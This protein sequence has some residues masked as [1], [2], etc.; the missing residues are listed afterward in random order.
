MYYSQ[1]GT[2]QAIEFETKIEKDGHIY[3]PETFQHAYGKSARLIV[4]LPEEN[5]VRTKKW[6][7]GSAKGIF[8]VISEDND[9]PDDF[10]KTMHNY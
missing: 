10:G 7:P 9:H 3:L 2:M 4:F 6:Q 5:A 8:R 1:E